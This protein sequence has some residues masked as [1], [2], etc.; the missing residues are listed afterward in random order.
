M[1]VR[2]SPHR[3][4]PSQEDPPR[5]A[6]VNAQPTI[7]SRIRQGFLAILLA[8]AVV[9]AQAAE[10][11]YG[12]G[13]GM[14]TGPSND[15]NLSGPQQGNG[16][17]AWW[18]LAPPGPFFSWEPQWEGQPFH[19]LW[20]SWEPLP[21]GSRLP[22]RN[23]PYYQP[24]YLMAAPVSGQPDGPEGGT[25]DPCASRVIERHQ[26]EYAIDAVP[27]AKEAI[28]LIRGVTW[29]KKFEVKGSLTG[30]VTTGKECCQGIPG[31]YT[32][33]N[34]AGT[35]KS[36]IEGYVPGWGGKL[37]SQVMTINTPHWYGNGIEIAKIEFG[38]QGGVFWSGNGATTLGMASHSSVDASC[39]FLRW[40]LRSGFGIGLGINLLASAKIT[41]TN[42]ANPTWKRVYEVKSEIEGRGDSTVYADMSYDSKR[43]PELIYKICV[44]PLTMSLTFSFTFNNYKYSYTTAYPLLEEPVCLSSEDLTAVGSLEHVQETSK[45]ALLVPGPWK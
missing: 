22:F 31:D 18:G 17:P 15:P 27:W 2:T 7:S 32:E 45:V 44:N 21:D 9:S 38:V 33:V 1:Q 37:P 12:T 36:T 35:L 41:V 28:D 13:M 26:I 14:G 5:K 30:S 23:T 20:P 40:N 8:C 29:V 19:D 4:L 24:Y 34:M 11:G 39:D 43:I 25:P 3:S 42:P 6:T 10:D 16:L